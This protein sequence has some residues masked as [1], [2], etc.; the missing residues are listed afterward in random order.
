V[1]SLW[2]L[3]N[4]NAGID[5]RNVLTMQ[6][7]LTAPRFEPKE[8][9]RRF[10]DDSLARIRTLPGVEVASVA[11]S[12]PVVHGGST[13]PI[14]IEGAPP[15]PIADQP[16]VATRSIS[17]GYLQTFRIPVVRGRDLSDADDERAKSV[18]LVS[19]T[20]A[21]KFWPGQDPVGKRLT[22]SFV[23]GKLWEVVGVVGD[24]RMEGLESAKP[25]PTVYTP[26]KQEPW[27]F[28]NFAVR[29]KVSPESLSAAVVK[30]IHSADPL[31]PVS[32]IA[33]LER[34]LSE[35]IAQRRFNMLLLMAF[36]GLAV[37]L[38]AVGIYSVIS[39]GVRRRLREIGIRMALGAKPAD[40]LRLILTEG[41]KPT[42]IGMLVG[43]MGAVALSRVLSSIVYGVSPTDPL[44]ITAMALLLV[45][46]GIMASAVP[47][48]RAAQVQPASILRDE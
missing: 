39:Y 45:C 14:Q 22:L 32:S 27:P 37:L 19:A 46:V 48:Y 7:S 18:L 13:Q 3:H 33:P 8:T 1:R 6:V 38:A 41:L 25:V 5:P 31:L 34:L 47:A 29:T 28:Y 12:L 23:P 44:T 21:E 4:V 16:A 20:M 30:E 10:V 9:R 36:A 43:I 11:S 2:N 15:K 17:P 26:M 42:V 35:S 24:V 40:V